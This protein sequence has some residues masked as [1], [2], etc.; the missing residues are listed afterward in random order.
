MEDLNEELWRLG[1][2]AKNRTWVAPAQHELAPVIHHLVLQPTCQLTMEI[3]RLPSAMNLFVCF[4]KSL[5][6]V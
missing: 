3:V 6:P 5:L 1:I 2:L 4:T